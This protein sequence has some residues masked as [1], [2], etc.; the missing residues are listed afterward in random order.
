MINLLLYLLNG[1][2]F[3]LIGGSILHN[4]I[5]VSELAPVSHIIGLVGRALRVLGEWRQVVGSSCCTFAV[6]PLGW[7]QCLPGGC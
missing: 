5:V 6:K 3:V 2:V 1:L 4:L 7:V